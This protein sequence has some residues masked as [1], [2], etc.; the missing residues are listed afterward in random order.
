[1]TQPNYNH[2]L[3]ENESYFNYILS[4]YNNQ[5]QKNNPLA[6]LDSRKVENAMRHAD[7]KKCEGDINCE[8]EI[9]IRQK[10]KKLELS[11]TMPLNIE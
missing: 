3:D 8:A 5:H 1:M 10:H 2:S 11:K 4:P 9:F 6:R 7:H